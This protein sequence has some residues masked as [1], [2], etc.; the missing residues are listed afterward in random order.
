MSNMNLMSLIEGLFVC[1]CMMLLPLFLVLYLFGYWEV[2]CLSTWNLSHYVVW[3]AVLIYMM[4]A[5]NTKKLIYQDIQE[6]NSD[7]IFIFWL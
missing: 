5:Q 4:L 6:Y 2:C 1:D 3:V 7:N